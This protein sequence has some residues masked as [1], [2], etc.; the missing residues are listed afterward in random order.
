MKQHVALVPVCQECTSLWLPSDQTRWRAAW[1]AE[2]EDEP[3]IA[4]Y[5]ED[6]WTLERETHQLPG[7]SSR[8]TADAEPR[9]VPSVAT[10]ATQ[11]EGGMYAAPAKERAPLRPVR[12]A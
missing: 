11:T 3:E 7:S 2:P 10:I 5:C 1:V 4:F 12:N 9:G 6:C 8:T